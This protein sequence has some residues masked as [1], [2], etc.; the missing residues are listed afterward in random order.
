MINIQRA[1]GANQQNDQPQKALCATSNSV[2]PSV[3]PALPLQE[4]IASEAGDPKHS[5]E[6]LG[7]FQMDN[8]SPP[9]PQEAR[10]SSGSKPSSCDPPGNRD[11]MIS[12]HYPTRLLPVT[13]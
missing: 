1:A 6:V 8:S 11:A 4:G 10:Q 7:G 9:Q 3:P 5:P 2:G 13:G 12:A